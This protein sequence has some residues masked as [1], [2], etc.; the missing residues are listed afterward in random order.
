[1][2]L[3]QVPQVNSSNIFQVKVWFQ[4]RRMKHKRQTLGKQ[5]DDGDDKDSVTSDGGKSTKMSDKFLDD[6][7]SKK[8]CQGCEMPSSGICG[9]HD[10]IGDIT[11]NRG[12]NNNTPSATNNNTSFNSNSN[13]SNSITSSG[14]FD[15]GI[16]EDDSKS[17][18]GSTSQVPLRIGKKNS[19]NS[20]SFKSENRRNSPSTS[21]RK[22]S[23]NKLSPAIIPKD[24]SML[25]P[26]SI[27]SKTES[28]VIPST[29]PASQ[30]IHGS[31]N[32]PNANN[33]LY[34][35]VQNSPPVTATA[36]ASATVTIQNIHNPNV[37]PFASR[38][39]PASSFPNQYNS[40]NQLTY[41]SDD[42]QSKTQFQM[43]NH[44][45]YGQV[46]MY[47]QNQSVPN[48]GQPYIRNPLHLQNSPG[49]LPNR[50]RNR[51]AY[52][53]NYHNQNYFNYT[54]AHND[55]CN[56]NAAIQMGYHDYQAEQSSYSNY[57]YQPSNM[58]PTET[59]ENNPTHSA[60]VNHVNTSPYY[61]GEN[62]HHLQ[63]SDYS[64]HKPTYYD[65]N[66]HGSPQTTPSSETSGYMSSEVYASSN[67]P[68]TMNNSSNLVQPG[69]AQIG[70]RENYAYH[71]QYYSPENTQTQ[72]PA[73]GENSNSSS[74]F[75]FLSN[76][77][78]DYTPE[79]YQ[80]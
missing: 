62:I 29:G 13:G 58:Y 48:E 10:E 30:R 75:N 9:S 38:G 50:L 70:S 5:G 41:S 80:I 69:S 56:H 25:L 3:L 49:E 16:S 57:G 17:N 53:S 15:K 67:P 24:Q 14:S 79:Y 46:D 73:N 39:S 74:D 31:I 7:M 28:N 77:A 55:P 35:Q 72:V 32:I 11:S 23:L 45:V 19:S 66:S 1:M 21:E 60:H 33:P 52:Q 22:S 44:I 59:I 40:S 51:Q 47:H 43:Q 4:N 8:S 27:P 76:L 34:P 64:S 36:V 20:L 65:S 61:I 37:P 26:D 68:L 42:R 78:N 71:H 2:F 18:E 54:K 12:N 63:K 6:E